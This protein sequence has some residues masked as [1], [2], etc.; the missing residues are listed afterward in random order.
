[1][2]EFEKEYRREEEEE[3]QW[4]KMKKE[5]NVFNRELPGRYIAKLLY[6]WGE[7]KYKQEY[8][9]RLEENWQRW[10]KNPFTKVSRNLFLWIKQQEEDEMGNI[11]NWDSKK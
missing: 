11:G 10:K 8:W 1:M 7:K 9:K 3:T 2:E 6:G 4:Q 5:K